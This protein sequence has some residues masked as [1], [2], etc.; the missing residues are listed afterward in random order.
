MSAG[1]RLW[2]GRAALF[3]YACAVLDL[4]LKL[5]KFDPYVKYLTL[6]QSLF[7]FTL[8]Q[9]IVLIWGAGTAAG[10]TG[11]WRLYR[12][13][14]AAAG[15]L[16]LAA[17]LSVATVGAMMF[18]HTPSLSQVIG[19][20]GFVLLGAYLALVVAFWHYARTRARD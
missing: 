3:W 12:G 4:I 13:K 10:L 2:I 19:Y 11:A 17:G 16:G 14:S 9:W 8:P 18:A 1:T 20:G 6:E 7:F 5:Q 15:L